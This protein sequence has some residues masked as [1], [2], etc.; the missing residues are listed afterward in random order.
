[1]SPSSRQPETCDDCEK[2]TMISIRDIDPENVFDVMDLTSNK[3]GI[4]TTL[5]EHIASNSV[6]IAESKYFLHMIP[7]AIYNSETLIGFFMYRH[8]PDRPAEVEI[9]RFMIDHRFLGKGLG[10]ASFACILHFFR[11]GRVDALQLM[12]D[13]TN[14]IAKRL[15]MSFGFK[16]TGKIYKDEHYYRLSL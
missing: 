3:D 14:S 13:D 12:I 11:D 10:K 4:G 5:E 16:F 8:M 2:P 9:N 15:Y 6:S 1:M 7:K